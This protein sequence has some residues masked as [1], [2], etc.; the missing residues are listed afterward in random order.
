MA[1]DRLALLQRIHCSSRGT[2]AEGQR[3]RLRKGQGSRRRI[4]RPP[5]CCRAARRC[6][7]PCRH[8]GDFL[9]NRSSSL[10]CSPQIGP[11]CVNAYQADSRRMPAGV[12]SDDNTFPHRPC[13]I[14]NNFTIEVDL[15]DP[16]V[17]FVPSVATGPLHGSSPR[18]LAA[19][20]ASSTSCRT[21]RSSCPPIVRRG[22]RGSG[23]RLRNS[24]IDCRNSGLAPAC[25]K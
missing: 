18:R 12:R 14:R 23:T 17:S 7:R 6:E 19:A 10:N 21:F 11:R 22:G 5:T 2:T 3:L 16:E 20:S 25:P 13:K 15:M 4:G 9:H 8:G 24:T 1:P